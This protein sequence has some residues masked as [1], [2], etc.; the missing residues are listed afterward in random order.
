ME[1]KIVWSP[2]HLHCTPGTRIHDR[3]IV[4]P[5]AG[6]KEVLVHLHRKL[7]L[8]R[9]LTL[10]ICTCGVEACK[11]TVSQNRWKF[12]CFQPRNPLSY[13]RRS[14]VVS[15]ILSYLSCSTSLS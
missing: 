15:G 10:M 13:H 9:S 8:R 12:A 14:L 6:I 4:D 2:L 7:R 1:I 5:F 11:A 3:I